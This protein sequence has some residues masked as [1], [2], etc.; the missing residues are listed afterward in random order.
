MIAI[1][2]VDCIIFVVGLS[3][4]LNISFSGTEWGAIILNQTQSYSIRMETGKFSG[5]YLTLVNFPS[6][7]K[8]LMDSEKLSPANFL[9]IEFLKREKSKNVFRV[10]RVVKI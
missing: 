4:K 8:V 2:V 10:N 1:F 7:T 6:I 3:R 5:K 9:R